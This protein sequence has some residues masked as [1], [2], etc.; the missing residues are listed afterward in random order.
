MAKTM[1]GEPATTTPFKPKETI[2]AIEKVLK[3][4][5][6]CDFDDTTTAVC[7]NYVLSEEFKK[8]LDSPTDSQKC[9]G[10]VMN[11]K[12]E[13][14]VR[15]TQQDNLE[16]NRNEQRFQMCWTKKTYETY[17]TIADNSAW[18]AAQMSADLVKL[19]GEYKKSD[20]AIDKQLQ[21]AAAQIKKMQL[22]VEEAKK[23]IH[24]I[25]TEV[26]GFGSST[27]KKDLN[28]IEDPNLADILKGVSE[29]LEQANQA[30][31]NSVKV[32]ALNRLN[33]LTMLET[34]V[35]EVKQGSE[36]L[37]KNVEENSENASKKMVALMKDY[38]TIVTAHAS[39]IVAASEAA[40]D[41]DGS[42]EAFGFLNCNL[43][44]KVEKDKTFNEDATVQK[45]YDAAKDSFKDVAIKAF[46]EGAKS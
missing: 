29:L 41:V 6:K 30:Y 34:L 14:N 18:D 27:V 9:N 32:A 16:A 21:T 36:S 25:K 5:L 12:S 20:E 17:Q 35:I 31:L 8:K 24:A 7:S 1:N 23:A 10:I 26:N 42:L 45:N 13:S 19:I 46:T 4:L 15:K 33:D 38:A 28:S 22:Q 39:S 43:L 11:L 37:K 44:A 3:D 2:D 40:S